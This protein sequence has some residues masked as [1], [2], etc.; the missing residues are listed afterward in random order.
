MTKEIVNQV[1]AE[2]DSTET[3]SSAPEEQDETSNPERIDGK[4]SNLKQVKENLAAISPE[5]TEQRTTS[6]ICTEDKLDTE[7][8][9]RKEESDINTKRNEDTHK[10]E[11]WNIEKETGKLIRLKVYK[12]NWRKQRD[13]S[14]L[15][16]AKSRYLRRS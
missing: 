9:E 12:K 1:A 16:Q 13:F 2:L 3:E 14:M 8:R 6:D 7:E 4:E 10:T 15:D 11:E 5:V